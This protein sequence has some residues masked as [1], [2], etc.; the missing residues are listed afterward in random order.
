M[1]ERRGL[2]VGRGLDA[3]RRLEDGRG[4]NDRRGWNDRRGLFDRR[5]LED[6]RWSEDGRGLELGRRSVNWS[7]IYT[8]T[9]ILYT[10]ICQIIP[11]PQPHLSL[12]GGGRK[13]N[14]I[15]ENLFLQTKPCSFW[16]CPLSCTITMSWCLLLTLSWS[17][18]CSTLR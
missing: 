6:V 3:G 10:N 14:I 2:E 11:Q 8:M 5:G 4:L 15:T 17:T 18:Q 9:I 12:E 7:D 1:E 13:I 16:C